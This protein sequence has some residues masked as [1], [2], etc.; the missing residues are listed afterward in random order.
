MTERTLKAILVVISAYHVITGSLAL[1]A[2]DTFFEEIGTYGVANSHY[3]GDVGAFI[4][5]FGVAAGIAVVR[6]TWRA[7]ILWLGALWY[8]FHAINH[9][10][11]T[12]EAKSGGRGWA[13][14]LLIAFG[15]VGA[16]WLARVAER[17]QGTNG[18]EEDVG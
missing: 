17:L 7:P 2:P 6:P 12:D 16:A 5:A 10:F 4:I 11:D 1:L 14:T 9:A 8:G 15:A 13:D 18:R 3:V